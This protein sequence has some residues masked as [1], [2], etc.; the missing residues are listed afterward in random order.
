MTKLNFKLDLEKFWKKLT[1]QKDQKSVLMLE[2][3]QN[4]MMNLWGI[5]CFRLEGIR[6]KHSIRKKP[7]KTG[8]HTAKKSP[9]RIRSRFT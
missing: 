2:L 3:D 4:R 1:E 5:L 7:L 9:H 6:V 8:R